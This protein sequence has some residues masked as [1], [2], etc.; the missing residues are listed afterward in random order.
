MIGY[1]LSDEESTSQTAQ[2][3]LVQALLPFNERKRGSPDP[4][5]EGS[6]VDHTSGLVLQIIRFLMFRL[7]YCQ[8]S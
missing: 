7:S 5:P 4:V 6:P 2:D 3:G 1:C 8:V